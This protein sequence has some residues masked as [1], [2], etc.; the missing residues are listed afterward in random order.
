MAETSKEEGELNLE[1]AFKVSTEGFVLT[2]YVTPDKLKLFVSLEHVKDEEQTKDQDKE[3]GNKT[4]SEESGKIEVNSELIEALIGQYVDKKRISKLVIDDIVR[5]FNEGKDSP[6]RRILKGIPPIKGR[7]GKLLLLVRKM[8]GSGEVYVDDKGW[9]DFHTVHLFDNIREDDVIG[10]VYPPKPGRHGMDVFG[11]VIQSEPGEPAQYKL[12]DT[13]LE[14]PVRAG[15]TYSELRAKAEGYLVEED[16]KLRISDELRVT[17]ELDFEFGKID[18]VGKV[19]VTGSVQQGF[20]INAEKGIFIDGSVNGAS[21]TSLKG[22]VVVN[23]FVFGGSDARIISGE[24][25]RAQIVQEVNADIRGDIVIEKEARDSILRTDTALFMAQGVLFGGVVYAVCGVECGTIGTEGE[26]ETVIE[27][28]NNIEATAAYAEL[29]NKIKSHDKA[30]ELME[31][32][33]GPYA[34]N[35]KRIEFLKEE[36]KK[37]ILGM[38]KKYDKVVASKEAL[39]KEREEMLSGARASLVQRVNVMEKIYP[40]VIMRSGSIEFKVREVIEG[41][42]TF[43]FVPDEGRFEKGELQPLV[44][45]FE[46]E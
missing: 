16:G 20:N 29:Q 40:G 33:L 14:A 21:L 35:R 31:L 13:I 2:G 23:G 32:H 27:L 43:D 5:T 42:C 44:C 4:A 24:S 46:E 8:T 37:K 19:A 45:E 17:G 10:R 38:L 36:H 34:K 41:P 9:A 30:I 6:P 22:P 7:D 15:K 28:C 25:F 18:F 39:L 11:N 3:E 26:V 12:D 1:E